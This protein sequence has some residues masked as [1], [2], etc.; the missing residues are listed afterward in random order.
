MAIYDGIC[1]IEF[2][3]NVVHY[4]KNNLGRNAFRLKK[5]VSK[6]LKGSETGFVYANK[7]CSF[8]FFI[9]G[10]NFLL[11]DSHKHEY[12][13]AFSLYRDPDSR[14]GLSSWFIPA[15]L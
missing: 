14:R 11:A 7:D 1:C 5:I 10:L 8:F 2:Y 12:T 4:N 6:N 15:V 9:L 3:L 13:H